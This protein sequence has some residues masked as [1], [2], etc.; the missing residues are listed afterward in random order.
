MRLI[1]TT[2]AV[3]VSISLVV[4]HAK[5]STNWEQLESRLSKDS[6]QVS[7]VDDWIEQCIHPFMDTKPDAVSNYQLFEQPSGLCQAH[8]SCGYQLCGG[9]FQSRAKTYDAT[10]YTD[11]V[12]KSDDTLDLPD[13]VVHPKHVGDVSEA[14]KFATQQNIGISVKTS[15][16]SYTGSSTKKGTLL[17]HLSKLPKYSLTGSITE[18]EVDEDIKGAYKEACNLAIARNKKAVIRV[19]GGQIFDEVLRSV[20]MDWNEDDNNPR[21]YHIVSGAAG[22]VSAAGGWLA[23]GG[24]S[25]N[26]GMRMYG[27]GIDQV[28]HVEMVLPSGAHVRFGPTEWEKRPGHAYHLTKKVDGYC[29]MGNLSDEDSWDWQ[30]CGDDI[31]IDFHDLWYAVRGGGGGA[32]GVLTS[33]YYQLH[34]FSPI[35]IVSIQLVDLEISTELKLAFMK[36]W[37]DFLLRFLY[38]PE[39]VG[40]SESSS[41]SCSSPGFG[42]FSGGFFVCFNGGGDIMKGAWERYLAESTNLTNPEDFFYVDNSVPSWAHILVQ[43]GKMFPNVPEGRGYDVSSKCLLESLPYYLRKYLISFLS[44]FQL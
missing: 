33:V 12:W 9:P 20:N 17:L 22:T 34:D 1:P 35:Q 19:G 31:E 40:V 26:N 23:S 38:D 4:D 44:M 42:G 32:Y 5:A 6:F 3:S 21:K 37:I 8:A 14:I 18:C 16:H 24:L 13:A 7:N 25:G 11:E 27:L 36:A 29:N 43:G 15:G 41:N 39:S 30:D 28:L 10:V 2:L